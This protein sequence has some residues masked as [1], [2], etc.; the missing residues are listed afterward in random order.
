[1]NDELYRLF[2]RNFPMIVREEAVA[3]SILTHEGNRVIEKRDAQGRLIGAAVIHNDAILMLC[4]DEEYRRQGIGSELLRLSEEAIAQAGFDGIT[5]GV[6]FDYL[7]PGVPTSRRYAPAVNECLD[8]RL[9]SGTSDFFE[10]RGYA[11]SWGGNCFDMRFPLNEF[12]GTDHR[13]GDAIDDVTYRWAAPEDINRICAC[14]DDAC[15]DFTPYYRNASFYDGQHRDR[16][17]IAEDGQ[18]IVGALVISLETEGAGLGSIG[19]TTVRTDHQGRHIAT[20]LV[21]LGTA[22]LKESGM[23]EAFLGY[24]YS[25]L[26]RLY[27]RAG[28]KICVYYMMAHK[29]LRTKEG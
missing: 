25:G 19:C 20:N 29:I 6:G 26:D 2:C 3:R 1:M 18:E 8:D 13:I 4:V 9:D 21:L 11:H 24:T 28:Y 22:Y 12:P 27:G 7:M 14:T 10:K 17:L 15:P 16:V 23:A 5:V